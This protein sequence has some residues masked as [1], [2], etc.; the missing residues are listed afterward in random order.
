MVKK[1]EG[2]E[3]EFYKGI[4]RNLKKEIKHL[5]KKIKQLERENQFVEKEQFED[6]ELLPNCV[7]CGKGY[8]KE[9]NL[10]GKN[11]IICS[12]CNFRKKV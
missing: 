5:N 2:R 12:L 6:E 4:I 10:I 9:I 1:F 11:F 3:N 8:L 7:E